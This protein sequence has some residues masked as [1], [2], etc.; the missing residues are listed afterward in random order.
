MGGVNLFDGKLSE[1][2][3]KDIETVLI[4]LNK[5]IDEHIC[6]LK[7]DSF[8]VK[9]LQ[10]VHD[11]E[12]TLKDQIEVVKEM[13]WLFPLSFTVCIMYSNIH[14]MDAKT[15][16]RC[17]SKRIKYLH[18]L[19]LHGSELEREA[20]DLMLP[21]LYG[22]LASIKASLCMIA[23]QPVSQDVINTYKHSFER[24]LLSGKLQYASMLYCSAQ[25]DQAVDMLNHCEGLLGPDVAHY[26][27]CEDRTYHDQPETFLR[28]GINTSTVELSKTSSTACV[29]FCKHELPC[30]PEHLQYEIYRM[31]QKDKNEFHEWMDMVVIDSVPF[32]Y[33]LQFLVY[34]QKGNMS[35]RLLAMFN[36][37]DYINQSVYADVRGAYHGVMKG[38]FETA[39][40]VLAHCWKL[41]N[42]Q[43]VARYLYG[44]SFTWY[45]TNNI[46]KWHLNQTF[47]KNVQRE[48]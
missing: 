33:Y 10:K 48:T 11:K 8:G 24:D 47:R 43:D 29:M 9:V 21:Y 14:K 13:S 15:A 41:E 46:A 23:N 36:M 39:L 40:N 2:D 19:Q 1:P 42:R 7:M 22:P 35:K 4:N 5:N 30:V 38:H 12:S 25:Y 28:K 34:S 16:V 44:L 17:V 32:L 27:G 26:C 18:G 20:A 45:P 31:T 3:I 6:N 37:M